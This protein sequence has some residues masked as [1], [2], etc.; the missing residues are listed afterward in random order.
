MTSDV[1]AIAIQIAAI[2]TY[3]IYSSIGLFCSLVERGVVD[4]NR[5]FELNKLSTEVLRQAAS[6]EKNQV[7]KQAET[8]AAD[9]LGEFETVV[10]NMIGPAAGAGHA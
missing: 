4:G 6:T 8:A 1:E 3:T 10:R 7:A 9:M 5:V 2:R